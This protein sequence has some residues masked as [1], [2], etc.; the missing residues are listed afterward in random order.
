MSALGMTITLPQILGV[1]PLGQLVSALEAELETLSS[2]VPTP[3]QGLS[4]TAIVNGI[5]DSGLS[6][7]EVR[8]R[9][10]QWSLCKRKPDLPDF[11]DR[12][13]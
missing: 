6:L 7:S 10:L 5:A 8:P 11:S 2:P 9:T 13:R 12:Q 3:R 1:F 4:L